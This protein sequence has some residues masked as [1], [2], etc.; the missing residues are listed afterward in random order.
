MTEA[1]RI[2]AGKR[3]IGEVF[4]RLRRVYLGTVPIE[5]WDWQD[6]DPE[7]RIRVQPLGTR[8]LPTSRRMAWG[9]GGANW[10]H[11]A[12]LTQGTIP[13]VTTWRPP[14]VGAWR[15]SPSRRGPQALP[16][17][18]RTPDRR[19]SAPPG[20]PEVSPEARLTV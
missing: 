4:E 18:T 17:P 19:G 13:P 11:V 10:S 5:T 6:E 1:Q 3:W 8:R 20:H 7:Y 9:S 16:S 2:A 15:R 12:I 14:C